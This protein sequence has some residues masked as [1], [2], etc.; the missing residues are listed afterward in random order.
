MNG[1]Q[2]RRADM[3][4]RW[5]VGVTEYLGYYYHTKILMIRIFLSY[6][7]G[8]AISRMKCKMIPRP[9]RVPH[10]TL[11]SMSG[12]NRVRLLDPTTVTSET[13]YPF[14]LSLVSH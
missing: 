4:P 11:D 14:S 5:L 3:K 13:H 1:N 12:H 9:E 6:L 7:T 2:R 10:N 8:L